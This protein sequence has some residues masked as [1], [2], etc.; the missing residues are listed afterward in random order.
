MLIKKSAHKTGFNAIPYKKVSKECLHLDASNA[1]LAPELTPIL[2]P[3]DGGYGAARGGAAELDCV[4][5]W[6]GVELLLHSLS[7]RPLGS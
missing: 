6:N 4:A 3:A 1:V 5:G 7:V 2:Q